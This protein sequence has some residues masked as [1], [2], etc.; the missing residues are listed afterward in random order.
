M[1][2]SLQEAP[3]RRTAWTHVGRPPLSCSGWP[4]RSGSTCTHCAVLV[5][6]TSCNSA[7][8]ARGR[9]AEGRLTDA[10]VSLEL[11]VLRRRHKRG[12]G[13][14]EPGVAHAEPKKEIATSPEELRRRARSEATG[15]GSGVRQRELNLAQDHGEAVLARRFRARG[16]AKYSERTMSVARRA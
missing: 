15:R 13:H 16:R 9:A 3:R 5:W 1:T 4:F 8:S 11:L 7:A 2:L 6:A 12:G 14:A 10:L